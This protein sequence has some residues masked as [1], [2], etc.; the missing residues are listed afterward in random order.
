M[1]KD[2]KVFFYALKKKSNI[3]VNVPEDRTM[4]LL[5]GT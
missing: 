3:D 1:W 5:I 4:V 2:E